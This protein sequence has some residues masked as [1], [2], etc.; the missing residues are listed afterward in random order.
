[1]KAINIAAKRRS[2]NDV[3]NVLDTNKKDKSNYT[4]IHNLLI[5]HNTV[6]KAKAN[7]KNIDTHIVSKIAE[8]M[9]GRKRRTRKRARTVR[10]HTRRVSKHRNRTRR[11]HVR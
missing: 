4:Q 9:G 2:E 5:A 10:R 8:F 6:K 3:L 11:R 1:M 7:T